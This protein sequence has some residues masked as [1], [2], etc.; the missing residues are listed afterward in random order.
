MENE[1]QVTVYI[2]WDALGTADAHVNTLYVNYTTDYRMINLP[3]PPQEGQL[4]VFADVDSETIRIMKSDGSLVDLGAVPHRLLDGGQHTDTANVTVTRGMLVAG[5]DV[6]GVVKWG[7]VPLGDAGK[8]LKSTGVDVSWGSIN[9]EE[10]GNRPNEFPP[11]E[12]THPLSDLEQ[13]GAQTTQVPKWNG[14]QWVASNVDWEEVTNKP[15]T[16]PPSP[17]TVA[18]A[19]QWD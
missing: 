9:W 8:V 17:H 10:I 4:R 12:H 5:R 16:F 13:S 1:I 7:G 11:S 15:S 18:I 6:G 19:P 2:D 3:N 14:S